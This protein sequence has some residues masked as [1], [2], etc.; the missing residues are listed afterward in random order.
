MKETPLI[1]SHRAL[2]AKLVDFS[3]WFMPIQYSGVI[4]EYQAVRQAVGIFDVSHM[5][6]IHIAG[7]QAEAFLQWVSTNDVSRLEVGHAQYSMICRTDGGILDDVFVY[8]TGPDRFLVC[9]N[10]SNREKILQ[11]LQDHQR[12]AYPKAAIRDDSETLAQIAIQGPKSPAVMRKLLGS[13]V[14]PLRPRRCLEVQQNG[15]SGLISRTGYTGEVGYEWYLP[16][17]DAPRAWKALL[18]TGAESGMKPAGL[19]ARDLLRLEVGYLLY[20]NDMD[21]GTSPLEANAAWVIAWN[22]GPFQGDQALLKQ[23]EQGLTRKLTGFEMTDRGIPRHDMTILNGGS[24]VG[25]VTSGNFSPVLQRGIGLGYLDPAFSQEGTVIEIDVRGKRLA[26][27]VAD[28]PFYKRPK[29]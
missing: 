4:D 11:W 14:E 6:R 18:E 17:E 23:K 27:Q 10:A 13:C 26:A 5:G 21:E 29:S 9:V 15:W 24:P 8:K 1:Q 12:K 25:K 2:H 28:P 16:A 7:E 22:K 19:G 20:G 3:G